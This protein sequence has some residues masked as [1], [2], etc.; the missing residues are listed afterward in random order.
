MAVLSI[1][2]I[3]SFQFF[4]RTSKVWLSVNSKVEQFREGRVGMESMIQQLSTATLD[5]YLGYEYELD[6][7]ITVPKTFGRRSELR[8]ISGSASS[9][10]NPG[11]NRPSHAVFFIAP[12]GVTDNPKYARLPGLLNLCG[13]YIEWSNSDPERP[14]ILPGASPFRFRLMQFVQPVEEMALYSRTSTSHPFYTYRT[15]PGWAQTA[16]SASPSSARPLANNVVALIIQPA[17]SLADKSG[18]LT[19]NYL[20]DSEASSTNPVSSHRNRLPPVERVILYS[21]D[22]ASAKKLEASPTMPDLC[23]NLFQDPTK[24]YP[25]SSD[26]GDLARFESVLDEKGLNYHRHEIAIEMLPQPWS[27]KN[28]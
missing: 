24:L 12:L 4:S 6:D 1:L 14:S 22:E 2:L 13:Y 7:N 3:L 21:I 5:Q 28:L 23:G 10:L 19:S 15:D 8:F 17:K 18:G 25:S 26:I 9:L 27:I 11:S 20:Y 16:L